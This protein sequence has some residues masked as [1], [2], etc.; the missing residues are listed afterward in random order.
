MHR[1]QHVAFLWPF[2]PIFHVYF[3]KWV[4]SNMTV[5]Y[6]ETDFDPMEIMSENT[7]D[8]RKIANCSFPGITHISLLF[9]E[10]GSTIT[11]HIVH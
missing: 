4:L 7:S 1:K 8:A 10:D 2:F 11:S 6:V 3:G 5:H 9:Q